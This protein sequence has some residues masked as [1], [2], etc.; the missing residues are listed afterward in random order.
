MRW[1]WCADGEAVARTAAEL[2]ASH[3]RG[4]PRSV[5]GLHT[6]SSAIP[7]YDHLGRLVAEGRVSFRDAVAFSLDEFV[8]LGPSDPSSFGAFMR[9]RFERRVDARPENVRVP[10]GDRADLEAECARYEAAIASAGGWDLAVLGL[11]GNGHVAF[12]EPGSARDSRTRVV[13]LSAR[14]R[15]A[16]ANRFPAGR[17][18]PER[19]ITVGMGTI[20][21]A[22]SVILVIMGAGKQAAVAALLGGVADEQVPATLLCDH[23]DSKGVARFAVGTPGVPG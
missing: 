5:L 21:A 17:A 7:M 18:V 15:A 22:R 20:L 12:N 13:A 23:P 8:G 11:G 3:V 16:N 4:R 9:E 10:A 19:A 1:R 6:G 2:V 14:T